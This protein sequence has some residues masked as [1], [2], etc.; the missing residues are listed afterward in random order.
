MALFSTDIYIGIV[1][2]LVIWT[3]RG[4]NW[5]HLVV[6]R[7]ISTKYLCETQVSQ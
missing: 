4:L 7:A 5:M 6:M 3:R 2:D 1:L